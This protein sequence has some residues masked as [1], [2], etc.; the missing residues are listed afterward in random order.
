MTENLR[1]AGHERVL[2]I[3]TGSG[4]QAAVLSKIADRVFSIEIRRKLHTRSKKLLETLAYD[5]IST[6]HADGY[7]GW[8]DEAPFD[9]IMI[10]AAVDHIPPPLLKQL[11]NGGRLILPLGNPFNYQHLTLV[12]KEPFPAPTTEAWLAW[13]YLVIFGS[14]LAFTAYVTVLKQLPI[15]IV[16][17]YAYVNPAIAM[18]LG[19]LFLQEEITSWTLGGSVLILL[20]VT[21]VFREK[22]G[23]KKV[24]G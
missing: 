8:P 11:K 9:C 6:R 19:W 5:N 23:K 12:T 18:L 20:G 21:G 22:Y 14:V 10:T 2:E 24:E 15:N 16:S 3:G 13:G 17:T 1:L 4:Y 7:F